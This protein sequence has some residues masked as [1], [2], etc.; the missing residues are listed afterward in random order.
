QA[1]VVQPKLAEQIVGELVRQAETS[2]ARLRRIAREAGATAM[3][4]LTAEATAW[5]ISRELFEKFQSLGYVPRVPVGV[6]AEVHQR[7]S[8]I[9]E[10]ED[11]ES[12]LQQLASIARE[13]MPDDPDASARLQSLSRE[14]KYIQSQ[15]VTKLAPE[16]GAAEEN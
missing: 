11:V 14:I 16:S 8:P 10:V 2:T 15:S 9:D 13:C 1:F 7:V 5:R 3:E 12:E 6:V 4:R